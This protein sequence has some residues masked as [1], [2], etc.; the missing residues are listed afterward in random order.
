MNQLENL[1]LMHY[2]NILDEG[3]F[4]GNIF[5]MIFKSPYRENFI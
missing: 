2:V 1:Y 3:D 5:E 4:C